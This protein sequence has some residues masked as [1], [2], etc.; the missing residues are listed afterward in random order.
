MCAAMVRTSMFSKAYGITDPG[1]DEEAPVG[2]QADGRNMG[3]T[4][5][6]P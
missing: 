2:D 3:M 6:F 5:A 4:L 1:N